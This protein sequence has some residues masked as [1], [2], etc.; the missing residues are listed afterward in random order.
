MGDISDI[1]ATVLVGGLGTR[2]R[3]VVSDRPKVLAQ[4]CGRPFLSHLL[5]Q[6]AAVGIKKVI[7]CTGYMS[8]KVEEAFGDKYGEMEICYSVESSPMGT[9]GA[10]RLAVDK[11]V[12]NNALILNGDSYIDVDIDE[13]IDWYFA[14]ERLVGLLLRDVEDTS[15]YGRVDINEDEQVTAFSEKVADSGPGLINAGMY[16]MNRSVIERIPADEVFSLEKKLFPSLDRSDIYGF[17][18]DAKFI[19][20]GTPRSYAE[21][22]SFFGDKDIE[23]DN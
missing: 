19:D 13:Y 4:V 22:E 3:S 15:R 8:E 5:D 16:L 2:L 17:S 11:L 12:T 21:A 6:I 10:V 14:K 1:T 23:N 9:G 7:L 20:I 18:C